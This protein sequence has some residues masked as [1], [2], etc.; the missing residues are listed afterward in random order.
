MVQLISSAFKVRSDPKPLVHS[1][2]FASNAHKRIKTNATAATIS[3]A[4][5]LT[6]LVCRNYIMQ[7]VFFFFLLAVDAGFDIL[8]IK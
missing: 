5:F 6:S 1:T 2:R 8:K 4:M 7:F 3:F